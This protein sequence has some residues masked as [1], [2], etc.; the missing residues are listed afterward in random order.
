[1]AITLSDANEYISNYFIDSDDWNDS[2]DEK[3]QRILNVAE[4]T[5]IDKYEE[6]TIPDNAV[7]EFAAT[8]SIVFNDTNRMQQ[9][10]IAGFSVTGVGS[11]T[12][13][14]NNVKTAAGQALDDFIPK[15]ARKLIGKENGVRLGSRSIKDVTI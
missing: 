13:K 6:Y 8:L 9:H 11:F 1:M 3:K 10:G 4:R 12:F 15:Q 5:L 14:E 7:Y 2:E